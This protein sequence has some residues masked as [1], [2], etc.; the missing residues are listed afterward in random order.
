MKNLH[1]TNISVKIRVDKKIKINDNMCKL[2][3]LKLRHTD[4][5]YLFNHISFRLVREKL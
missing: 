4:F 5:G 1:I 2:Q 3:S